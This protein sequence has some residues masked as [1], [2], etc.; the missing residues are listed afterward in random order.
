MSNSWADVWGKVFKRVRAPYAKRNRQK[1]RVKEKKVTKADR[2]NR[3][4]E[5]NH[6]YPLI[7]E[8]ESLTF[9]PDIKF[10]VFSGSKGYDKDTCCRKIKQLTI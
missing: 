8:P 5:Q 4:R 2:K 10:M 6:R 7:L 3:Q 1:R 9:Y